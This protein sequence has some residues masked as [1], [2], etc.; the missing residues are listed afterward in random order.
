MHDSSQ[1]NC[2]F[3]YRVLIFVLLPSTNFSIFHS[4]F[5]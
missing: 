4:T 5:A 3:W 1:I 2:C